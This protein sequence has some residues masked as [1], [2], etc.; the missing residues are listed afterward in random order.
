MKVWKEVRNEE[1]KNISI[2]EVICLHLNLFSL[3]IRNKTQ[4][5]KCLHEYCLDFISRCCL[6]VC[7]YWLSRFDVYI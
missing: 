1:G 2:I 3:I 5:S 6:C 4:S 7:A